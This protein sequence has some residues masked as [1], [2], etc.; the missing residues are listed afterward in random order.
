MS[1]TLL[2]C[3]DG[4]TTTVQIRDKK[5]LVEQEITLKDL[6]IKLYKPHR[7]IE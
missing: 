4:E 3:L 2:Y 5:T 1:I 6:Y 7:V